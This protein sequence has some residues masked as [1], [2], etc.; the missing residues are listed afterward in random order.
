MKRYQFPALILA[1]ITCLP[2]GSQGLRPPGTPATGPSAAPPAVAVL[3]A[4][5]RLDYVW[6]AEVDSFLARIVASVAQ[7]RP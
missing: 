1:A 6:P 3:A 2:A 7:V 4:P 5:P